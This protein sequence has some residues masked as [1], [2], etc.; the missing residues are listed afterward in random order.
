MIMNSPISENTLTQ[1]KNL[2]LIHSADEAW[3]FGSAANQK[4]DV[5]PNDID[6]AL[7][8]IAS[9]EIDKLS[10]SL[11]QHFPG[12]RI[13]SVV[14]YTAPAKENNSNYEIPFHFVLG[15]PYIE[16]QTYP[17]FSSIRSGRCIYRAH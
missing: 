3:L 13:E 2:A 9:S 10:E 1:I 12:S 6:I 14:D 11:K 4:R 7:L 15:T 17:I 5:K 8:G 16:K